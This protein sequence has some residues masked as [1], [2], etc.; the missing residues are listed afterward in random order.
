M[1]MNFSYVTIAS[2]LHDGVARASILSSFAESLA[3]IG[4]THAEPDTVAGLPADAPLLYFVLTGGTERDALALRSVRKR[5]APG[6]PVWLIAHPLQNSLPASLEILARVKR[7]GGEGRIFFLSGAKDAATLAELGRSIRA[8]T[9]MRSLAKARLG[10]VGDSS[11]WLVASSHGADVVRG[12]WGVDVVPVS[13]D[14]LHAYIAAEGVPE[15]GPEFAFFKDAE[16]IR[17]PGPA[18]I[19][20]SV[21]VYRALRRLVDEYRL[22]ALTLRCF[23][24][25]LDEKTTGCFALS[26]LNDEGVIAG[27]EGDIPAALALLWVKLLTGLTGWMAN[28]ARVDARAGRMLLAHCTVPRSIVSKYT[29]RSHF[30]SSLGVGI[31][32]EFKHGPVTFVRIGGNRLERLWVTEGDIV[33]TSDADG[34]CRTQIECSV[35]PLALESMLRDPLGNH[36]VVVQ[37]HHEKELREAFGM[38]KG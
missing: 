8:A 30:E 5:Q 33:A 3:G 19:G 4:G 13:I 24:L 26:R 21:G 1:P 11:D 38:I 9:A 29:I 2:V 20:K 37:G 6:E 22:D 17:E 14:T 34:L 15:S 23:D 7:D 10:R 36:V 27:C 31:S 12:G 25:V 35:P 28:P 18:D 32:G 16:S